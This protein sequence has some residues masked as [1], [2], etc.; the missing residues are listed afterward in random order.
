MVIRKCCAIIRAMENGSLKEI[1]QIVDSKS[2]VI[3]LDLEGLDM[4][5]RRFRISEA[6]FESE[7]T[8]LHRRQLC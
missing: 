2:G 3:E 7:T 4:G 5:N 6:R 8:R 1:P